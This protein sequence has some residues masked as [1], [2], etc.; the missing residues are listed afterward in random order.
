MAEIEIEKKKTV[1]PWVLLAILIIA[2]ILYFLVFANDDDDLEDVEEVTTTEQVMDE[3][4]NDSDTYNDNESMT[5]VTEYTDYI[6]D[7]RMGLDHEYANGALM[8]LLAATRTIAEQNGVN[9]EAELTEA[10]TMAEKIT[11]DPMKVT[12]A[13]KIKNSGEIITRALGTVQEQQFPDLN[14]KHTAVE[15]AI[16]EVNPD[17]ETLN[18]KEAVKTFFE[19][20]EELLISM[21]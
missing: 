2:A 15:D 19:K 9:S 6:D 21:K 20:A 16:A 7:P 10:R 8:K 11:E 3:T 12:H 1:W 5:V 17:E 18:Q 14:D 4:D 13:N